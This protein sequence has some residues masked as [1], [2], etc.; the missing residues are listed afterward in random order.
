VPFL[1]AEQRRGWRLMIFCARATRGHRRPSLDAHGGGLIGA[2][3]GL[4]TRVSVEEPSITARYG[5]ARVSTCELH[6]FVGGLH[7]DMAHVVI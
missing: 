1:L 3:R 7:R 4:L 2:I 6:D 5:L